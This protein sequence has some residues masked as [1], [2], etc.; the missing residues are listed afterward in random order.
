MINNGVF[1][2]AQTINEICNIL[3]KFKEEQDEMK[4]IEFIKLVSEYYGVQIKG[5]E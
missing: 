1:E 4:H 5:V 2:S 3:N